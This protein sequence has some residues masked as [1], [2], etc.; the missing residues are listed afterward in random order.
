MIVTIILVTILSI[1]AV[2][3]S[4]DVLQS[5]GT[6][7][8]ISADNKEIYVDT[9]GS[10]MGS[11]SQSS[12]YAT[13]NKA[14]SDVNAS[15]NAIIHLAAGTY[16][17]ENNTNL[18]ITMAHNNYNGSLTII[19][20]G[21]GLIDGG[22]ETGIISSISADSIV[23]LVNIT[24]T[25]GRAQLGSA[26]SSSGTLTI[27]DCTFNDNYAT[28]LAAVYQD[29][30]NNVTIK[31]SRFYNNKANQYAD[32]Y[33]YEYNFIV[34]MNNIFENATIT[35]TYADSPSVYI[36]SAK[37]VIKGNTFR[38][39]QNSRTSAALAV[40][41]NN[42]DY[43][44]NITDNTFINCNF[45][46]SNGGIIYFQNSY[47]KNNTF[48]D[49]SSTGALLYSITDFNANINLDDVE[50]DGTHF[51]LTGTVSDDMG[52]KVQGAVVYFYLDGVNV[53]MATSNA[54]GLA[55]VTVDKILENGEY[56]INATQQ[57]SAGTANPF[58]CTIS[59]G[60]ATVNYDHSPIDL[61]VSPTGDDTT[62]DGSENNP[63]LTLK[64]AL[65]YGISNSI[66]ITV[67]M[68]NG[69][70]NETGDYDLSYSNVAKITII[71]ETYGN[72]IIDALG[73]H[74]FFTAG[75]NTELLF[76]NLKF[77]NGTGSSSRSFN[78]RYL[79]M[80]NCSVI[81]SQKFYA[82]N[83][84]SHIVF[85]NVTWINSSNLMMYNP[86]IYD[87]HFENITSSGTGNLWMATTS[88]EYTIIIENSKFINLTCTGYSG[89]GV[90]YISGG[91]FRSINNTYDSCVASGDDCGVFSVTAVNILSINDTFINNKA[92]NYG[93]ASFSNKGEN[94]SLKLIDDK[95]IS[96]T[97]TSNGGAVCIHGGEIINSI[98]ENNVAGANGGAI[99]MDT[100]YSSNYLYDLELNNV[101]FKNNTAVNG[102]DIY[103]KQSERNYN[104]SNLK[105]MN[106][107]FRKSLITQLQDT[108]YADVTHESGAVIG[109]G[110]VTFYLDGAFMGTATVED[111]V[112]ALDYIGF[113]RN[114][115]YG[116]SGNYDVDTQDTIHKN[117][118]L[119]VMLQALKENITLY[120]SDSEG[121]DENGD[122]SLENPYKTIETAINN[123][124]K[125]SAVVV[126]NV[127]EGNYTGELNT[128]ITL[129]SSLDI[130][131]AG[132][133]QNKTVIDGRD[134]DWFLNIKGGSGIVKIANM[135]IA[136]VTKNYVDAR[137]Y[138]QMPAITIEKYATVSLDNV[139]FTRCHGTEGGAILSNGTLMVNNSYFFNNGD[140]NNG[141]AI[142][143]YGDLTVDNSVFIANHAKYYSTIYNDGVLL[144]TNSIIEDSMRVNGWTGNAM[145]L[146]GSGNITMINTTISRS[147][148]TSNE[149]I[150]TGQTWANNPG[151]AISI[152][153]TGIVK[154][155]NSTIDGNNKSYSAQYISNVAFGG[156][157]SIGVFVPYGLEVINTRILN[158]KDIIYNSKGTNLLDSCYIE[159]V[160]YASEGTSYDY[161]LTVVNSYFADGTILVTKK[162]TANVTLNDNWWGNNSQPVYKVGSEEINPDT[163]LILTVN[164]TNNT[165]LLQDAV[166]AFKVYDGE[167]ITDYD[168]TLYP[169]EF[170]MTAE[171]ATLKEYN[172]TINNAIVNPLKGNENQ[173]YYLEATVDGQTVNLTNDKL[174]M[175]NATIL[176]ED[177]ILIYGENQINVSVVSDN[178]INT[179]NITLK[180]NKKTYTSGVV[181]GTAIFNIEVLPVG[182]YSLEYSFADENVFNP[183]SNS[184]TLFVNLPD[185]V[186]NSTF[187]YFFDENGELKDYVTTD[188]LVFEGVFE[189]LDIDKLIINS[190]I[191]LIA[192]NATLTNIGI[193][194]LSDN[195]TVE[196][197]TF[198]SDELDNVVNIE[199][200]NAIISNNAFDVTAP[201]NEDSN[202]IHADAD[203]VK[204]TDN[205]IDYVSDNDENNLNRVIYAEDSSNLNVSNNIINAEIPATTVNW[206]SN[207]KYS[208]GLLFDDCDD[209]TL[210]NNS[211]T[212]KSNGG[213]DTYDT[214]YGVEVKGDDAV[215]KDN[216]IAV[217]DA[218]YNYALVV[219]GDA[220][221]VDNNEIY[222]GDGDVY[223]CG[224]E[225][226]GPSAGVVENN[227][228]NVASESGYGVYSSD[229]SGDISV[230]YTGNEI[231]VDAVSAF[232]LSLT[233]DESEI[234]DNTIIVNG[235]YTTGIASTVDDLVVD[236]NSILANGSDE[237]TPAGYDMMGIETTGIHIVS[238]NADITNNNV[239]S[240]GEF[241]IDDKGTGSISNNILKARNF[242]GDA[243]VDYILGDV[244]VSNNTPKMNKAILSSDDIVM[245][246]KNGTRYVVV[247]TDGQGNPL[248]NE[249][250]KFLINGVE[251]NRS[252]NA[253]GSASVA[254]NLNV[255]NYTLSVS[256]AGSADY[257]AASITNKLTV[258]S[259]IDGE[260]I[261][262][263]FKN[264]TQYY[265]SFTDAHGN[266]LAGTLVQF[267]I[268]GVL[269]NR[270]TN[271]NG[272]A[273]MNINL[274]AGEYI[275]TAI[276]SIN[277][278]N[279]SNNITVLS[280]VKVDNLVKY[281]RN[282]SQYYATFVDGQ[283]NPLANI[284]VQFNINGV[285]YTR[286]TNENG[287]A[288][289]NINLGAGNYT[290][291]AI[292]T[293]NNDMA[294][295]N[296]EV[297]P[298][299]T[300]N[301][302]TKVKG[303]P[304][305]F[306]AHVVDG[307]G[308]S[309]ANASVQFNINGVLYNRITKSDGN[310]RLNINLPAGEYIITSSYNGASIG[311]K[312]TVVN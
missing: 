132:E 215:I 138:N 87:S 75:V 123:G 162:A 73:S 199:G 236:N 54:Q 160:T 37:S 145:V 186:T 213:N 176:A 195:V 26:I 180:L 119:I 216:E 307:N 29:E 218:P 33:C 144:L 164:S 169:R 203:N 167:N 22:D 232:G 151:F 72:T 13:I 125:Q 40:R 217:A 202:V 188:E 66:D 65:D 130:T 227:N 117:S 237:G 210:E 229:W 274:R 122:G 275:I 27:D 177:I 21:N 272:T 312:V 5:T 46:G 263:I 194:I 93:V 226:D 277:G 246:Y 134:L 62:G 154:I 244:S 30:N 250:L 157:G 60:K 155:V 270:T 47:L 243:S 220:F 267:N 118:T 305:Q 49:C 51:T 205:T 224:I 251:Y 102:K 223:S 248:F 297:L 78:V 235:N 198:I 91:N 105:N 252:T 52:N 245:Y 262:K 23:T 242:T 14:I 28:N 258:L 201:D 273:K 85:K 230:N 207:T 20:A 111:G 143:N 200:D 146:G 44:G 50:I 168:G 148:K 79:T 289:M 278:Q 19:G 110:A 147:G 193:D 291:T 311:N 261:V 255:G 293:V 152:G 240:N 84:P 74:G 175:G 187:F 39:L 308:N 158:L 212:V 208:I 139:G 38:N 137:L 231:N 18:E 68:K 165:G 192:N 42:N 285:L 141:A 136:N 129:Y 299:L 56:P 283:G 310:A 127:L 228:I 17:G 287:T 300:T 256:Y 238:G 266:P 302:L 98:F 121:D 189:N 61:W 31:N 53:G 280:S 32:F 104:H 271:K 282:E 92:D 196:G 35:S 170:T 70:Y 43:I 113:K 131:I 156:S 115:T 11:G 269:Y 24:F 89:C 77:V 190:P 209:L 166:L 106:V 241:S 128:N 100:Y 10:D 233:G 15:D 126:V 76:R 8:T 172:G 290:I 284:S 185:S 259:T 1:S 124:I 159:N 107:T 181:N 265:A 64:Q 25:H 191:K 174:A 206:T 204:I 286:K 279:F 45:T 296:I 81:N 116:L 153:S 306:I 120:V 178:V 95:F 182:N 71:G 135:T 96:N 298:I 260:N 219:S 225:I 288:K 142:K 16:T 109:G 234:A 6:A 247:L 309:L 94:P 150:G 281:Y 249:T 36:G 80:E 163:W 179:G 34:L 69:V 171:N 149:I 82:Q 221:T 83:S 304:D 292:N 101:S 254:L 2:S 9:A 59:E 161:N 88:D 7:D 41:Y 294:S 57:Y 253:N 264:D 214:I 67:H 211:I 112:A 108:V 97:A 133:G 257:P 55:S 86:E 4:D 303:S 239:T 90:A 173:G 183:T 58:E 12:P 268:N 103:I 99:Y 301:D 222:A 295:S 114:G 140:S 63:F 184:S 276:N 48:I 3:A 197:F